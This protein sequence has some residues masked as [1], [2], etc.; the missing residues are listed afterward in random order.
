MK[1]FVT[2]IIEVASVAMLVANWLADWRLIQGA[3]T[4]RQPGDVFIAQGMGAVLPK[5]KATVSDSRRSTQTYVAVKTGNGW[6]FAA[7][8]NTRYRPFSKSVLGRLMNALQ[9]AHS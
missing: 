7:F 6:R 5:G 2:V 8:Q 4:V 1:P 3:L 9:P